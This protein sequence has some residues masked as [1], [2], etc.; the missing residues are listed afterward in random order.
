MKKLFV[1]LCS[2][3]M[4]FGGIGLAHAVPIL[5]NGSLTGP[6]ANFGVPPSWTIFAG[7]P[8]TMDEN[9]NV[10]IPG[11][12]TFGA[13][14]SPS[15]DG[16]TWVG[17]GDDPNVGF[18][19]IF[20]Q[21]VSGFDIGITYNVSWYQANFGEAQLGYINPDSIGLLVD[22]SLVGNSSLSL[23]APG[24]TLETVQFTATATSHLLSFGLGFE[25]GRSY[26][27]IDGISVEASQVPEPATMLLLGTGLIGLAAFR[28][29]F[30]V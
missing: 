5:N 12:L 19:E 4:L 9:S 13:T 28:R 17:I 26:L 11:R 22:G 3:M 21:T 29:K 20:G 10:G 14:P 2:L 7:S 25:P 1:V 18:I 30:R 15:P 24:W 16:G 6:I 27:S 8:D 23:L